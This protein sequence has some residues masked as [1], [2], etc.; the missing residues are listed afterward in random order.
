MLTDQTA[1]RQH[2]TIGD[3]RVPLDYRNGIGGKVV[4]IA[5]QHP[6]PSEPLGLQG[7]V[8]LCDR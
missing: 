1:F 4:D 6:Q 8:V 5:R 7:D 3:L 2:V